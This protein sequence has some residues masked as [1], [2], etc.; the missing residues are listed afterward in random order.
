MSHLVRY[1]DTNAY[2]SVSRKGGVPEYA[3]TDK[4]GATRFRSI[5]QATTA[6][7]ESRCE[8]GTER[9]ILEPENTPTR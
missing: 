6:Y 5:T 4:D 1:R 9:M 7:T 3:W 8:D 2:L